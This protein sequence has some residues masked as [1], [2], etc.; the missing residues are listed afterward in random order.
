MAFDSWFCCSQPPSAITRPGELPTTDSNWLPAHVPGTVAAVLEHHGSWNLESAWDLDAV[1]W[2]YRSSFTSPPDWDGGPVHLCFDGL[3]TRAEVWLNSEQILVADNMFRPYRVEVSNQL[4]THNKLFI[5]FRSLT[6]DLKT[7]RDRPRWKTNLVT[8]QQLRWHRTTLLGR[9]PG[10][11]PPVPPIGPW[12]STRLETGSVSLANLRLVSSLE[13]SNGIV[14][15]EACIDSRLPIDRATL[16][17]GDTQSEVGLTMDGNQAMLQ[18]V[19]H[20]SDPK[21]WWPHTHGPQLLNVCSLKINL[22]SE[23]R[24]FDCGKIGFRTARVIPGDSFGVQLNGEDIYCRGA[25]WTI[26][27]MVSF[28]GTD[29]SIERDLHLAR[30]AGINM[31]RVGGTMIYESDTFY[32]LCDELGIMVWQDFMFA[33][34]DYPFEDASFI[35]N[36]EEEVE[37]QLGRLSRHPSITVYCGNSE[38]EQQAAMLGMPKEIWRA[39]WFSHRLP[40]LCAE[41]HPG[42]LYV[43]STPSGGALPFHVRSG[44]AHYYG[45]GAYRR[46]PH[47]LRKADVKFTSECLGFANVPD[48]STLSALTGGTSPVVHHPKWKRGGAAR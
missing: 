7:K 25:C 40:S 1:D 5:V 17:V 35:A 21:L 19:H 6:H 32:R 8:H 39:P 33:N 14:Q 44:I 11:S 10:W 3:A 36:V 2:W 41:R 23:E 38:I 42:T 20:V 30:D 29:A 26:S 48:A 27:D 16:I 4:Q 28:G 31:L 24:T 9:I 15:M 43:P 47:E 46:S 37:Y 22:G 34:M 18:V 12:R 13:G 45:I